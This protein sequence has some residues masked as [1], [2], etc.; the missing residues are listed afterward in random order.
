[1]ADQRSS[2]REAAEFRLLYQVTRDDIR[3]V[4]RQQWATTYYVLLL[5]AAIVAFHDALFH[6][7]AMEKF[8]LV[9]LAFLIVIAG[10]SYLIIFQKTLLKH[11]DKLTSI[12]QHFLKVSRETL[13]DPLPDLKSFQYYF[14]AMVLPFILVMFLGAAF[15]AWFVYR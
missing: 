5:I 11:R 6:P 14:L 9:M 8:I 3:Y 1:M 4:K 2:D 15:V 10:T 7:T 13:L 12:E